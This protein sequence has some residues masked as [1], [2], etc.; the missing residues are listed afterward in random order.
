M[1]LV[2]FSGPHTLQEAQTCWPVGFSRRPL[3]AQHGAHLG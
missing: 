3:N 1:T 2:E